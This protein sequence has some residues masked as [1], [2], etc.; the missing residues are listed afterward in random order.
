MT[1]STL[2]TLTEKMLDAGQIF[3]GTKTG[4]MVK[5]YKEPTA[6]T[7]KINPDYVFH[8]HIRDLI[9]WFIAPPQPHVCVWAK[10]IR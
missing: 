3:S 2:D 6:Y 5:G 9:V 8:D 4:T 10:W 7:P 1:L